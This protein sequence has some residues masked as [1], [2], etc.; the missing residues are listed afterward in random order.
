MRYPV[1]A[2]VVIV[3]LAAHASPADG[4]FRGGLTSRA[5]AAP[6]T[7]RAVAAPLRLLPVWWYWHIVTPPEV[8]TF[9]APPV[10]SDAPVGG[11]QLDVLPWSAQVYVDGVLAGRVEQFRGYYQHLALS[12]GPHTIAIVAAGA[13]PMVFEV[14][15]VPGKT[16]THR[17]TVR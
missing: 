5:P 1:A 4:Q 17:A 10:A 9:S 7:P 6:P 11:V 8:T 16:I 14:V 3:L 12:A 13:E 2:A 15:V